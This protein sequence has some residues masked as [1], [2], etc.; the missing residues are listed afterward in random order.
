MQVPFCSFGTNHL[1]YCYPSKV[2]GTASTK[3]AMLL[4]KLLRLSSVN[5]QTNF[6][7]LSKRFLETKIQGC[8]NQKGRRRYSVQCV[9]D[10]PL[11]KP[12]YMTISCSLQVKECQSLFKDMLVIENFLSEEEE[13]TI[14]DEV[15][16]HMTRLHYEYDHWD[17][18]SSFF[19]TIFTFVLDNTV[20]CFPI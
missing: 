1:Q 6:R 18:V 20:I 2:L 5:V 17:N 15:E 3:G 16:P 11:S 13:K 12:D 14:V 10:E 9:K 8:K 19:F 4:K 7:S